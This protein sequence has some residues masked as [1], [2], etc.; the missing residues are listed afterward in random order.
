MSA[1]NLNPELE[2]CLPEPEGASLSENELIND[3]VQ[4]RQATTS[5]YLGLFSISP[6]LFV[7][8][9]WTFIPSLMLSGWALW[10]VFRLHKQ[11]IS[12]VIL[13][14]ASWIM[15]VL[16]IV[17]FFLY[18][19]L[20]YEVRANSLN[21]TILFSII[22]NAAV[23]GIFVLP[24]FA[25]SAIIYGFKAKLY[26]IGIIAGIIH[27]LCWVIFGAAVLIDRLVSIIHG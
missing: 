14:I 18:P 17:I 20:N 24:I 2:S 6:L 23:T 26:I 21:G 3:P 10:E 25:I 15:L 16:S 8:Q 9:A 1:E 22:T 27:L 12:A 7:F 4:L 5:L 13:Q 19:D 11:G